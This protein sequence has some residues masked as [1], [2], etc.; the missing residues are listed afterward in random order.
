MAAKVTTMID[1]SSIR[2]GALV[3]HEGK[4]HTYLIQSS[5]Q[6]KL[7]DGSWT[8]AVR[9]TLYH[10]SNGPEYYRAVNNF[11]SFTLVQEAP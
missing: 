11:D 7:P 10:V 2:P 5:G 3:K 9:Y 6:M 4:G 8:P 1:P